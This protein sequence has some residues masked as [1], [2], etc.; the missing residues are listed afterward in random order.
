VAKEGI[1]ERRGKSFEITGAVREKWTFNEVRHRISTEAS[2]TSEDEYKKKKDHSCDKGVGK[3][4]IS[5]Q[6]FVTGGEEN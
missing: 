6:R 3:V 1:K 5:K 4:C 2:S